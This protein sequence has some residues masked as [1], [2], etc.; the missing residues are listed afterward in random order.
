MKKILIVLILGILMVS[1]GGKTNNDNS[2]GLSTGKG[3]LIQLESKG[4]LKNIVGKFYL[5][6]KEIDYLKYADFKYSYSKHTDTND[7]ASIGTFIIRAQDEKYGQAYREA[8]FASQIRKIILYAVSEDYSFDELLELA[9]KYDMVFLDPTIE[10]YLNLRDIL[11]K[12]M[13][14]Y[15]YV[16]MLVPKE[17]VK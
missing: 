5:D 1:C 4:R 17:F 12:Q 11:R 9:E 2:S 7:E 6:N 16:F 13:P 15:P 14:Q 10:G 8:E 3:N